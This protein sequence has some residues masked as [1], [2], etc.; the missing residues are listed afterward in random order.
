MARTEQRIPLFPQYSMKKLTQS[1]IPSARRRFL[2]KLQAFPGNGLALAVLASGELLAASPP[3]VVSYDAVAISAGEEFSIAGGGGAVVLQPPIVLQTGTVTISGNGVLNLKNNALIVQA[4]PFN[5][6]YGYVVAGFNGGAW[7]G[8]GAINSST[9]AEDPLHLTALGIIDNSEAH[10]TTFA[11]RA[12]TFG[13]ESLVV[14]TYYG[15]ANLDGD[16][17]LADFAL[18]GTG[19]G[20]NPWYHGDFDYSGTVDGTDYDLFNASFQALHPGQVPE[21]GSAALMAAAV[22]SF[23]FRRR[24]KR[25]V[26]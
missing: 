17:T 16:V 1:V 23:G 12:L 8:V 14:Y 9:A 3:Q 2:S 6:I 15:D 5:R 26:L 25:S 13:T 24:T 22:A 10:Y 18:I 20:S 21:P 19:L 11:G 7:N 4:S